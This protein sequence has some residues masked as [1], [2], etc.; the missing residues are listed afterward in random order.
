MLCNAILLINIDV[1]PN[2][3]IYTFYTHM[4]YE[5][6]IQIIGLTDKIAIGVDL[7]LFYNKYYT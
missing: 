6:D 7:R 1:Q 3:D 4:L 5:R 2:A